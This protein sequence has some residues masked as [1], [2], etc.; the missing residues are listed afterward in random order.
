[1]AAALGAGRSSAGCMEQEGDEGSAKTAFA[2]RTGESINNKGACGKQGYTTLMANAD[3]AA[4]AASAEDDDA[5]AAAANVAA[6]TAG[7]QCGGMC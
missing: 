1:M 6:A 7:C 3:D 5:A 4:A 2:W